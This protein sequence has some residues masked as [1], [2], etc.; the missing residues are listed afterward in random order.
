MGRRPH[1]GT[2]TLQAALQEERSQSSPP[3]E[4]G[5]LVVGQNT[6]FGPRQSHMDPSSAP[7]SHVT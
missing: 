7:T 2:L 3:E 6:G 5:E 1:L 4:T